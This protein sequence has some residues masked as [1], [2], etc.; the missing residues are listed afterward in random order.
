[1][2]AVYLS[3][4]T[5]I[6]AGLSK[7]SSAEPGWVWLALIGGAVAVVAALFESHNSR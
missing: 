3:A 6:G 7:V 2:N 5:M 1:M 4:G